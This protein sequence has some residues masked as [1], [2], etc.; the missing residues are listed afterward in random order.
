[1]NL[2]VFILIKLIG[3]RAYAIFNVYNCVAD[4]KLL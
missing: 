4:N 3:K 1:M 2:N